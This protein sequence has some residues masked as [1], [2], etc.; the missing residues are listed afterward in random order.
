[1]MDRT[2][3]SKKRALQ[4]NS[5]SGLIVVFLLFSSCLP[6]PLD[7]SGIPEVKKEI[8]VA[9]QVLPNGRLLVLLTQTMGALDASYDSDPEVLLNGIAVNDATVILSRPGGTDTLLFYDNGVY[10]GDSILFKKGATYDLYINSASLG[11]ATASTT[12][13]DQIDFKETEIE[14]LYDTYDDTL[15]YIS[16]SLLDPPQKNWYMI[17]VKEIQRE[18]LSEDILNPPGYTLLFTDSG[19]IEES[20]SG[21][22]VVYPRNYLPGDTVAVSLSNISEEYYEF[23]KMRIDNRFSFI[24]FI[25]E[26][27][28]YP[29][30]VIGG[31]GYFNMYIPDIR[32]FI[33]KEE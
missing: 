11:T 6:E 5:L 28:N 24:E 4:I 1:M 7:I 27:I 9:S 32:T 10:A 19:F 31:R 22:F 2:I 21:Q 14:L 25:G 23:M 33:L 16:Y 17:S 18:E 15:A 13:L 20:Y 29:S 12:L 30:N 8:V 26:P 3:K